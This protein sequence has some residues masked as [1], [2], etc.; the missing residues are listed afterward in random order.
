[1]FERIIEKEI[2]EA[3]KS[4]VAEA[5]KIV[6]LGHQ[7]PDGDALGSVLGFAEWTRL[8]GKEPVMVLPDAFPDF[9]QWLPKSNEILRYD[10]KPDE[11]E[12]A[13]GKA[14]LLVCVD[15]NVY[16]RV[17]AMEPVLRNFRGK[18]IHIDHH[19]GPAIN[20]QVVVSDDKASSASELV[21]K[22]VWEA[23]DFPKLGRLF[24]VPVFTGLMTDTG[25]FEYAS[26][27]PDCFHI[28]AELLKTGID[29]AKIHRN[30]YDTYSLWRLRLQGYVLNR[31]LKV[32]PKLHASYFALT[33]EE[34]QQFHFMKGDADG[35]VN[36]PLQLK[37]H[38]LSISLRED[39]VRENVVW[40][41]ARSAGEFACNTFCAKYY[42]GG[43]HKNASGG[44][45][46][47]SIEEAIRITEEAISLINNE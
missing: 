8:Y 32:Y 34:L 10:K 2:V 9:L 25:T 22:I 47:C 27:G 20:A 36:L 46:D 14:D 19:I 18:V 42:N 16:S 30:V 13:M 35:L 24:H 41:S 6:V 37:G 39:T 1:M 31:K 33:K 12:R 4:L 26:A 23:G 17:D 21:F 43:G 15:F 38:Q 29:K 7:N 3:I 28:V 11:V 44:R 5:G 40:V 45:L